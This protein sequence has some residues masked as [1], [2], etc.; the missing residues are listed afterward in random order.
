MK[1]KPLPLHPLGM[2]DFGLSTDTLLPDPN[3]PIPA[4]THELHARWTPIAT[5]NS[6]DMGLVYLGWRP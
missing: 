5:N 2:I 6:R 1:Q 4:A 3:R